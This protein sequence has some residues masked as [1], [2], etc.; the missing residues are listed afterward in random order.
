MYSSFLQYTVMEVKTIEW[1]GTPIEAI[2]VNGKL[3]RGDT[4]SLCCLDGPIFIHIRAFLAPEPMKKMR[5]KNPY[6]H[7]KVQKVF[8]E[9]LINSR[10]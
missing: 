2:L 1:L 6:T 8:F 3:R 9:E 4:I 10:S 7:H 5:I